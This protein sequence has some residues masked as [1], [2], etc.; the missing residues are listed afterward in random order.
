MLLFIYINIDQLIYKNASNM[1]NTEA[2]TFERP[3]L[4]VIINKLKMKCIV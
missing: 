3:Y 2:N 4:L 1:V